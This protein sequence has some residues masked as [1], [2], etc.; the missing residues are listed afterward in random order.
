MGGSATKSWL[1]LAEIPNEAAN[2]GEQM[3]AGTTCNPRDSYGTNSNWS[4]Q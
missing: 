3:M 1:I 2:Q 4:I